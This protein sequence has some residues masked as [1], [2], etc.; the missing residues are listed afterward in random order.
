[1]TNVPVTTTNTNARMKIVST[2]MDGNVW[3]ISPA[4]RGK[5]I[6]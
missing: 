1:M 3:F 5:V 6:D 4:L 2:M